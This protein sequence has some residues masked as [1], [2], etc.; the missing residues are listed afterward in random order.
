MT[1][2]ELIDALLRREPAWSVVRC[3]IGRAIAVHGPVVLFGRTGKAYR[4]RVRIDIPH[5]FPARGECPDVWV[6]ESPF[7]FNDDAHVDEFGNMCL[8]LRQAHELDYQRI[9]L[10]GVL[11]HVVFHLDRLRIH[12]LTGKFPGPQYA[13]GDE[14]IRQ[15]LREK[16]ADIT[17]DLPAALKAAVLPGV[18]IPPNRQHCPCGSGLRFGACHKEAVRV[19]RRTLATYGPFPRRELVRFCRNPFVRQE[20]TRR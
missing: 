10:V 14:G 3:A 12:A 8:E 17:K 7:P 4:F 5:G 1:R 11:D 18:R 20:P 9:G 6:L 15:F 16:H 2:D 13:H 19:A